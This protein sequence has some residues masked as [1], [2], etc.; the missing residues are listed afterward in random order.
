MH[1]TIDTT[2]IREIDISMDEDE[3]DN[4]EDYVHVYL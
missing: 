1:D 3:D 2:K 4:V